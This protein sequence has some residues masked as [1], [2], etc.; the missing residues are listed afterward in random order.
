MNYLGINL[1]K[2]LKSSQ[3]TFKNKFGLLAGIT[4]GLNSIHKKKAVHKDFH[5]GNILIKRHEDGKIYSYL[6]DLGL[7]RKIDEIDNEKVY[8]V[9]PYIAPEVLR[10]SEHTQASDIY[11]FGIVAYEL[12]SGSSPYD[13]R[14]D[15]RNLQ[16]EITSQ[17]FRPNLNRAQAPQLLKELI[18]K[19]WEDDPE[20][21][22]TSAKLEKIILQWAG[23]IGCFDSYYINKNSKFYG[24][25]REMEKEE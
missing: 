14:T 6:V 11:S 23:E 20:L 24:Q 22:P 19:C 16:S 2:Y 9:L 4:S 7:C 25:C 15:Y 10:G 1:Q 18:A 17:K 21:R 3:L 8:G 5:P 13:E 12:F